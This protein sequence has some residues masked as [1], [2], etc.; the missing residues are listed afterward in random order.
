MYRNQKIGIVI[1]NYKDSRTVINLINLISNYKVIDKIVIVDNLSPDDS[2]KKLKTLKNNIIDIIQ[3]DKNGGYSYGNNFGAF[4]L[5]K[6]YDSDI[7]FIANPDV[8]FDENFIKVSIDSLID[9]SIQAISGIMLDKKGNKIEY[10]GKINSYIEDILECTIFIKKIMKRFYS[11]KFNE[12]D[13]LI[14]C[15]ML[16]GSLFAIKAEIY[17]EI[18]GLDEN[19]FLYFEESILGMKFKQYNYKLAIN[20]N[21]SF[22]HMHSVSIN[23]SLTKIKQVKQFYKSCLY[24]NETYRKI[25]LIRKFIMKIFMLYGIC[26]R[27]ILYRILY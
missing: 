25:G 9:Y 4:Y 18:G 16:A 21:I 24:F 15:E 20:K 5:M 1:L 12:D 2:F 6:N 14:F 26:A 17:K 3:T 10:L 27:K 8:I 13:H 22:Y 23:K 11:Y 19:V 7:I